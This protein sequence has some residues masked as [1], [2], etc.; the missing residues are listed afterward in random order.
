[1][2][3]HDT[4]RKRHLADMIGLMPSLVARLDWSA[5]RLAEHRTARLRELLRVA[6]D[7][8]PWHRRRLADV[9]VDRVT[10]AELADLPVM[11]KDDLMTHFAE[12]VTDPRLDLAQ[13]EAHLETLTG[14]EKYLLDRYHAVASSGSSG[15]RGV[16]VWDWDTWAFA[17]A[18]LLRHELR[19]WM[20]EV[21]GPVT[22][23]TVAAGRPTHA[24]RA[25]F[26]TFSRP[27][28]VVRGFSIA[29]PVQ[30]IVAGLNELRPTL[31][32]G[33]PSGLAALA[34]EAAAG[35]LRIAP[36][37]VYT[38]A[39][40][41]LPEMRGLIEQAW[42]APVCNWWCASEAF[43]LA[44]GCGSGPSMHLSDDLLIVEPVDASGR[45][46]PAGTRSAKVLLTN[47]TNPV[48]PLIRYELT[49]EIVVLDEACPC[50]SAHRLV[51]DVEGR[52][53]DSFDYAGVTVHPHVFRSPLSRSRHV[54]EYQ[55]HQTP[56]GAEVLVRADGPADLPFLQH[57][58]AD[59]LVRLGA[60][61]RVTLVEVPA[62]ARS[63][64][65]KFRRFVPLPAAQPSL[66]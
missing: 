47:L 6:V 46:V 21:S 52:L 39:E 4:L 18:A 32:G 19:G 49:D 12:I 3:E 26:Q 54:L 34:R 36:R 51:A 1:M 13:V 40:P 27:E 56:D 10:E 62:I 7:R 31:L 15:R 35:D 25:I 63:A 11:T 43:P 28:L 17:Y 22:M 59:A 61:G 57:E 38:F 64:S 48:L 2:D 41:L 5:E 16:F 53:D 65:G 45:A 29:S 24:S 20:G 55:V 50:R 9:D 42:S 23:A 44:V 60:P 37:R 30:E 58:L 33:Y 66:V 8:S 14:A